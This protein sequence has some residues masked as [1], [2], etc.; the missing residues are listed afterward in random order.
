MG[1]HEEGPFLIEGGVSEVDPRLGSFV[2]VA[3]PVPLL[4]S[5]IY[6]VPDG[7]TPPLRGA[8]VRV[9]LGSRV[10]TGCVIG[11]HNCSQSLGEREGFDDTVKEVVEY[12]DEEAFL[13]GPVLDLIL[14]ISEYYAC[15]PGDAIGAA[16]PPYSWTRKGRVVPLQSAFKTERFVRLAQKGRV[17]VEEGDLT[18]LGPRQ[19]QALSVLTTEAA[20]LGTRRLAQY[21][22]SLDTLRRLSTRGL[23]EIET[24]RCE[25]DPFYRGRGP[26][27]KIIQH[28]VQRLTSD[29]EAA[30][31]SLSR[32]VREGCFRVAMLHGVTG[33]GKTELYL[34]LASLVKQQGRRAL[35]LVPEIA[36]APALAERFRYVFG[37]RVAIQHSGLTAGERHDQW[38]RIR[39]GEVDVVVG[40]RSAVFSP[41]E[42]LGLIVVDEEHDASYKQEESPRYHG[43]DAAIVRGRQANVLVVLGSATPSME[44]Y[45]NAKIGKYEQVVLPQRVLQRSLPDVKIV[46]MRNELVATGPDTVISNDLL[47]GLED[48]LRRKQQ[49]LLLLNRRGFA[50]SVLCRQ[51]G[52]TLEC[53]NC[54]VTLTVH[55]GVDRVRCHYCN[56]S[57][58]P[59]ERCSNCASPFLE[60]IG[61]GTERIESEVSRMLPRARVARLDR[62]TVRRKGAVTRILS[63]FAAGAVD[64][65]IGTQMVAKGH[66][67]PAVTLVGVISADVGLGLA[68][69]RAAERT[70]Q[71]L[72]QVAGRSG[73]G[74]LPGEAVIQTFFPNHYSIGYSCQQE[75]EQFFNAEMKYRQ[76][77][78][79]PP[80][81]AMVNVLVRA[82]KHEDAMGDANVLAKALRRNRRFDVLGP[83]PAALPK[84]RGEHRVQMFLKGTDRPAMRGAL[85]EVLNR[86]P[87]L[88]RRV[89]VDVDPLNVL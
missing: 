58:S 32:M 77:M 43:R 29:Q 88:Q 4:S 37:S 3:V 40:T 89:T 82:G 39:Q 41:I 25:R 16:M 49:A 69:F 79:Y 13:S 68:D 81:V 76:S 72:T 22:V 38:H 26:E 34:R 10:V 2:R 62:D 7:K 11:V 30:L 66:D 17:V 12:V 27:V 33:S 59:P 14:W 48:R 45:N 28:Q 6:R 54:S 55:R 85:Q 61:F 5:L 65:L 1:R 52:Q 75:Y 60:Q 51:C 84:L 63:D 19:K 20:G 36:L 87:R 74:E 46:D 23:V 71:L 8:R 47:R 42:D 24:R 67:F 83:A 64:I 44:T 50:V 18:A 57:K 80:V 31:V 56:Y 35:V 70:F 9:P 73:R 78:R 21:G 53:P 86:Y 15:G